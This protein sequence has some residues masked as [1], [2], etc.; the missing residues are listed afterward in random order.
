MKVGI[1][2]SFFAVPVSLFVALGALLPLMVL[3]VFSF[4]RVEDLDLV[5]AFSLASWRELATD[6]IYR[7]LIG[8]SL[9]AGITTAA[10]AAMVGYPLAVG[11]WRLNRALKS[12]AMVVLLTPLYTGELVRLYAWRLVLG[13]EGLLNSFLISTGII[14]RPLKILLFSPFATGL[15][16]LY[17]GL[18]FMVL[19][20]WVSLERIDF[21]LMEAARDL[22]ARPWQ[23]F[24]KLI[25]PLSIPGL[26]VGVFAVFALAAGDLLTPN[27]MGGT[28]GATAMSMI[29]SLFGTAFDWP[30]AS[31]LAVTLLVSLLTV[32]AL[33]GVVIGKSR[34]TRAVI[35]GG[36]R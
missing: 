12:V 2:R 7:L 21:S 15:V 30:M 28:S 13:S 29:D 16:L 6:P 18:P 32:L 17:N 33:F 34:S 22:G 5:P 27:L 19:A 25:L 35:S 36:A 24:T 10:F 8:K 1:D 4:F 20:I 3:V 31:A 9:L 23:S 26:A 14:D 11:I